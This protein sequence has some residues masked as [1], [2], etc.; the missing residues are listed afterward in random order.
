VYVDNATSAPLEVVTATA[1][2]RDLGTQFEVR[3]DRG[4]YRLSIREG[5][6]LL[7]RR[8]GSEARGA[9]GEEIRFAGSGPLR[10][11][12]VAPDDSRWRWV[13][14]VAPPPDIDGKPVQV[15]LDWVARETGRQVRFADAEVARMASR[16]TL[17]G[18][19]RRLAPLEALEV[20]LATTD[21]AHQV[22][23]DGTILIT[24]KPAAAEVS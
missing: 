5:S 13:E 7:L 3:Y 18:T 8:G 4:S 12:R 9:A 2:A 20:M 11:G 1:T 16:T 19:I 24:S 6:V 15:L 17:H 10:V 23:P 21:L 14:D 22:L